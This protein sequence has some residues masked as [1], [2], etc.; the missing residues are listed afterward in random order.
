MN[1]KSAG[2]GSRPP[3]PAL[4]VK[5]MRR[6]ASNRIGHRLRLIDRKVG[7]PLMACRMQCTACLEVAE[8]ETILD[9]SD[10]AEIASWLCFVVPGWLYCCWR[11]SARRKVCRFC[12]S[13]SLIREAH[14]ARR[15]AG[16][17]AKGCT[18]IPTPREVTGIRN[19][20]NPQRWPRALAT[21]RKRL[22][23]G[24]IGAL[25]LSG[26]SLCWA[27]S[28]LPRPPLGAHDLALVLS[29][30]C[31]GWILIE[32]LRIMRHRAPR[33]SA[34]DEAGRAIPIEWLG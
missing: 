33:C 26:L 6:K 10:L 14:A 34:W 27:I 32:T 22:M 13:E 1:D 20:P 12:G 31:V 16:S 4:P 3:A 21:P 19:A 11:H 17:A 2:T 18:A 25:L 9:G 29:Y 5:R 15:A 8:P 24:G 7:E 28:V 23:H 30:L